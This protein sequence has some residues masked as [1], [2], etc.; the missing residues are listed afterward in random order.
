[1]A[2]KRWDGINATGRGSRRKEEHPSGRLLDGARRSML[3]ALAVL[4]SPQVA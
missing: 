2:G 1:M 4:E 3:H